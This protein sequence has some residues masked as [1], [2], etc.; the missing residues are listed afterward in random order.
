MSNPGALTCLVI[1]DDTMN[2]LTLEH[3]IGLTESLQ[4]VASLS[5]GAQGLNF[6]RA[7]NKVD[8]LFL[9]VE[10]PNL[11]G[12][13]LLRVLTDPPEVILATSYEHFAVDAFALR[14]TDYL[15]KPF[16]YARFSQAVQ[17]VLERRPTST[18]QPAPPSAP[19]PPPS[20]DLFVKVNNRMVRLNFDEVLYIEALSD[21]VT[22]V[23]PK[24]K[25]IVYTTLKSF[26]ARLSF[27]H[28]V[29]VHRSYILN[30]K[31]VESIEDNTARL[32]GGHQIPIGV[33][34]QEAFFRNLNRF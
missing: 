33:S 19:A 14:V 18:I 23:T 15:V 25:H 1:D 8:L 29:R 30:M 3:Y 11:S 17:R 2:R 7:G 10:M 22:I 34:Y 13:E 16:D 9:D 27:D 12:L 26:A 20:S 6:F 32:P 28:F 21:Y 4:L 31:Q 24:Q 5:D